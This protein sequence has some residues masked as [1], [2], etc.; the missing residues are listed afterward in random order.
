MSRIPIG[1]CDFSISSYSFD[2]VDGDYDLKY[3]DNQVLHDQIA[4]IP[5][6]KQAIATSVSSGLGN[7]KLFGSPWSPPDWLKS[8][9]NGIQSMDGSSS[10]GGLLQTNRAR[11]TWANYLSKWITAYEYQGFDMWGLT[12][13]NEPEF[14]GVCV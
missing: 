5:F 13:Q 14:A 4:I 12:V 11:N 7:I 2:D 3:F 10:R 1:S 8:K 9:K 6:I